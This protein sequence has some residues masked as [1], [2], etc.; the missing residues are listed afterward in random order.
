MKNMN[1]YEAPKAEMIELIV[2]KAFMLGDES[3]SALG[4]T[5]SSNF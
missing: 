4:V 2:N 3:G 1:N 5:T